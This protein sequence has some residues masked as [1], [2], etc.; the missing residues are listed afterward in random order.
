MSS[1]EVPDIDAGP[2]AVASLHATTLAKLNG[3][4]QVG[5]VNGDL[6]MQEEGGPEIPELR[7]PRPKYASGT[8][9]PPNILIPRLK[10]PYDEHDTA[11]ETTPQS[12]PLEA[13]F[14]PSAS[15][16]PHTSSS[17][18]AAS[19]REAHGQSAH[20]PSAS[21][22]ARSA[23]V[24]S[25]DFRMPS[26]RSTTTERHRP[27]TLGPVQPR[28]H[29]SLQYP[30]RQ[31]L[32]TGGYE[33]STEED[34]PSLLRGSSAQTPS[35]RLT[36]TPTR[37]TS[38]STASSAH[39]AHGHGAHI[40]SPHQHNRALNATSSLPYQRPLSASGRR[41]AQS[42]I[43]P[44]MTDQSAPPTPRRQSRLRATAGVT[45][46][47]PKSARGPGTGSSPRMD[48]GPFV[49]RLDGPSLTSVRSRSLRGPH[50]TVREETERG[51]SPSTSHTEKRKSK[52]ES[53]LG[54]PLTASLG[55]GPAPRE[56]ILS[57]DQLQD[58][59][60]NADVASALHLMSPHHSAAGPRQKPLSAPDAHEPLQSALYPD[61]EPRPQEDAV[62][63][64][65]KPFLVSAP[66]ALT[67]GEWPGRSR[68]P[69][70]ASSFVGPSSYG[71]YGLN[72]WSAPRHRT[73]SGSTSV[74]SDT[75]RHST[76]K[77]QGDDDIYERREEEEE[78]DNEVYTVRDGGAE[79]EQ[80]QLP[81]Q[82]HLLSDPQDQTVPPSRPSAD[83]GA[84]E[85]PLPVKPLPVKERHRI[86]SFFGLRKK[87]KAPS[88]P[89]NSVRN[90]PR[91]VPGHPL[92]APPRRLEEAAPPPRFD[93]EEEMRRAEQLRRAEELAQG[94]SRAV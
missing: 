59:L 8:R 87:D 28:R 91:P 64:P 17:P 54:N 12:S 86:S 26:R 68:A 23:S 36:I 85:T 38:T 63:S 5:R 11:Y 29:T 1:P 27:S 7:A 93:P 13:R 33:S 18:T 60:G 14:A 32:V 42:L 71:T 31:A 43:S 55:L 62:T 19:R 65:P 21:P 15:G 84:V 6:A 79:Q 67:N 45:A 72:R 77:L 51:R 88:S 61:Q 3:N 69:S 53:Q 16:R 35:R 22:L 66:P 70:T 46:G 2:D 37:S 90:E 52:R 78:Q 76:G 44:G 40:P 10:R 57:A 74:D 73:V 80:G 48:G 4:G 49:P 9:V 75:M 56:A 47:S 50:D 41:R 30:Q 81:Q 39:A 25:H 20:S 82:P 94:T 24:L 89:P 34:D 92:N 58:L 83:E